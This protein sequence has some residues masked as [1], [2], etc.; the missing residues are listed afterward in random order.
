M[1]PTK[2]TVHHGN[3]DLS[4]QR[5]A[6][7]LKLLTLVVDW[8][9]GVELLA[10][11]FYLSKPLGT[12]QM[13]TALLYLVTVVAF[14]VFEGLVSSTIF[15]VL[16]AIC[17]ALADAS[18]SGEH[19]PPGGHFALQTSVFLVTCIAAVILVQRMLRLQAAARR[20]RQLRHALHRKC[21]RHEE[22]E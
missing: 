14:A 6:G 10:V 7:V 17:F 5:P 9:A 15:C 13:V 3:A 4:T 1:A 11:I 20:A 12:G 2:D 16:T 19:F 21:V 22:T 18:R 8:G